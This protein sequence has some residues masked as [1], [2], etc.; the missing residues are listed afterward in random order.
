MAKMVNGIT[1]DK[2]KFSVGQLILNIII[3]ALLAI[4]LYPLLMAIWNALKIE[5]VFEDTKWYPVLPLALTN[6]WEVWDVLKEYIL[7]T[8]LVGLIGGGGLVF[9]ASLSAYTFSKMRF[10]GRKF[11][12]S[13]VIGLMMMPGIIT[14]IPQV[15]IYTSFGLTG[16]KTETLMALI[17]PL[18]TSGPIFGVFL[19]SSFF[20]GI[21]NDIFESARIDGAN[22][23]ICY[24]RIA[25]PLC[26][27]IMGTLAIMTL[28]NIWNDYLWPM[29]VMKEKVTIAAALIKK[30]TSQY[31]TNQTLQFAG[32]LVASS[33]IIL[34][35]IVAN[36][37][38]IEGLI[39]SSIK[40]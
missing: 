36:K 27:P 31:S 6:L 29:T 16:G 3:I 39:G 30:F 40:L 19:L 24:L 25:L 9:I 35:F 22:E 4:M 13:M 28:V 5:R 23:F 37:Y 8:V 12:Y 14:L 33:P 20:A 18:W 10:P 38:Y 32:Y 2:K 17:L 7:Y 1:A 21:P 11:L 26:M 34:L 15:E